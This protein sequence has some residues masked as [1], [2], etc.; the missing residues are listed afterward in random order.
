MFKNPDS[1]D[2]AG[3]E[4]KSNSNKN[5]QQVLEEVTYILEGTTT[6]FRN[7]MDKESA[8]RVNI[9][10]TEQKILKNINDN[11]NAAERNLAEMSKASEENISIMEAKLQ[12]ALDQGN[13]EEVMTILKKMTQLH[14]DIDL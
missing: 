2:S 12:L 7:F 4:V 9:E 6:D 8:K 10:V 1:K 13:K 11:K 14:K 5:T 3:N